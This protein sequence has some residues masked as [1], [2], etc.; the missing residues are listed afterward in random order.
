MP[1]AVAVHKRAP[2]PAPRRYD[3]GMPSPFTPKTLAFLRA[4]KRNNNREWFRARKADYERHVR[5]PM[6]SV[7]ERLAT[8]FRGF[9]PELVADPKVSLFRVYRDTRFSGDKAPLKTTAGARFPARGFGKGEGAGLYFEIAPDWVWIGG[10]FY[11][12][13]TKD[14]QA[15]REEIAATHPRLHRVVT[16]KAFREAVG[17]LEGERL[18]RVPRG[19]RKDAPAAHYLQFKQFLAG[20][21]YEASFATSARFYSELVK[22]F[23]AVTPLVRFLN[24][25]LRE[26]MEHAPVLVQAGGGRGPHARRPGT[27]AL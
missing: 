16:A 3:P 24:R 22:V 23:K 13:S 18:S 17:E 14:L 19:Y 27:F 10:G 15:I 26:R 20:A 5:Q 7:I 1:P 25:P 4:M 21:E 6:T 2:G 8:D 12:P 9:A 11:M